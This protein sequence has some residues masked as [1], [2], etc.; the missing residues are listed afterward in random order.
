MWVPSAGLGIIYSFTVVYRAPLDGFEVPYVLAVVDLEDG[1]NM[2]TNIVGID[3]E[4][5]SIGMSVAVQWRDLGE[6]SLP[7]FSPISRE[8]N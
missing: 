2:M 5:V 8:A 4:D 7:V 1:F 6:I 3:P